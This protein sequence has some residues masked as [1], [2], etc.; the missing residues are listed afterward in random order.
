MLPDW[1]FSPEAYNL[2]A[3]GAA[4]GALLTAAFTGY[5]AAANWRERRALVDWHDELSQDGI[6]VRAFIRNG[7]YRPIYIAFAKAYGPVSDIRCFHSG[8]EIRKAHDSDSAPVNL[9]LKPGESVEVNFSVKPDAERLRRA[10]GSWRVRFNMAI[11]K[12]LWR[13]FWW[14]YASG[15]SINLRLAAKRTSS[16]MRLKS[17]THRISMYAP[18]ALKM[19]DAIEKKA[20]KT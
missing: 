15:P 8:G 17:F 14:R 7:N 3:I 9:T 5:A 4:A 18:Q 6:R 12:L 2:A 19:A 13:M 1:L 11:A 20:A 10:A 16:S